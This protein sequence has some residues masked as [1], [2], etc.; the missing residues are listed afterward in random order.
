MSVKFRFRVKDRIN[1]NIWSRI[2]LY[3]YPYEPITQK[4]RN[5]SPST[6]HAYSSIL[7]TSTTT[8]T[9]IKSIRT[10]APRSAL[11]DSFGDWTSVAPHHVVEADVN[12]KIGKFVVVVNTVVWFLLYVTARCDK[13]ES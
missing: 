13:L 3:S 11:F 6:V 9:Y 7:K 10:E 1:N 2:I 8:G 4:Q 12:R 5:P